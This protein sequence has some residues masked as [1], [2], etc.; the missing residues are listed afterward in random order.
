MFGAGC[1]ERPESSYATM[2]EA[3]A[4]GEVTRGW[5]PGELPESA[6]DL[7]ERHD[8]DTNE[9][10]GTFRFPPGEQVSIELPRVDENS[11]HV[12]SVRSPRA[13]WWPESMTGTLDA[14][15]LES[16]GLELYSTPAPSKFWI[17]IDQR[18]RQGFFWSTP[19]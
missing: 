11:V 6:V 2:K 10:W 3:R 14:R 16:N 9:V 13:S 17:A 15:Y 8:V 7:H 1:A 18:R 19:R 4:S 5:I 12:S